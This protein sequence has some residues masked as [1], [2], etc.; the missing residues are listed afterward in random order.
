MVQSGMCQECG[1]MPAWVYVEIIPLDKTKETVQK[2][3]C[4]P[5]AVD[6]LDRHGHSYL[7]A[8]FR[9]YKM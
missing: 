2:G 9:N 3:C 7:Q 1:L 6:L 4:H 8:N 5:C